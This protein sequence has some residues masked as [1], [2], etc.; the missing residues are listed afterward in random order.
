MRKLCLGLLFSLLLVPLQLYAQTY[1]LV[2]YNVENLFD[3]DGVAVFNDYNTTDSNGNPLY[4]KEDVYTKIEHITQVL[5]QY[6]NGKGPDVILFQELE[7]DFTPED[8]TR[9]LTAETFLKTWSHTTLKQMLGNGFNERIKD[10]PSELLLLKGMYDAGLR[11]Y[12][13]QVGYNELNEKG[14][15][16]EAQKCAVFTRLPIEKAKTKVYPIPRGRPIL[17]V[18]LKVKG[19][20]L[21]VF[22]NH[23]KAG[24]SSRELEDVRLKEAMILRNRLNT[25]LTENPSADIILGGDF[26]SQYNQKWALKVDSSGV[27][28]VLQTTGNEENVAAGPTQS[29]YNLWYELPMN[30]RGS[31]VYRGRWGTLMQIMISHGMYD[32][33]GIQYV[34]NSFSVGKFVGLNTYKYSETPHAWSSYGRGKGFSDHLPVSMQFRVAS[35]NNPASVM[36]LQNPSRSDDHSGHMAEVSFNPPDSNQVFRLDAIDPDSLSE[37]RYYDELFYINRKISADGTIKVGTENQKIYSGDPQ[38]RDILKEAAQKGL[39]LRFFARLREYR[40][41]LEWVIESPEYLLNKPNK[42]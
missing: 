39:K 35:Q 34:D 8:S 13:F 19:H 11:G 21:V 17:E 7:S 5:K 6:D 33:S 31:D 12:D 4:T 9:S 40:N 42:L 36:T 30:K 14:E 24:A 1:T 28:T 41:A 15:P 25:L 2:A 23:W 26:N 32:E 27:N 16:D 20:D 22:D 29:F 38:V 37:Y 18:W 10:L 3:A